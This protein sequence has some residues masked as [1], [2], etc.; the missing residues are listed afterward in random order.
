MRVGTYT[1]ISRDVTG[2]AL[3][4][5]RQQAEIDA[6]CVQRGWEIV[7]RYSDNDMSA[8]SLKKPRPQFQQMLRDVTAGKIDAIVAK[9][10]D[11]L[12]RRLTEL[13]SVLAVCEKAG[14]RIVTTADGVDTGSDGGRLVARILASVAQGEVE[15][16]S[17]RQKAAFVQRAERGIGWGPRAFG[18]TTKQDGDEIIRDEAAAVRDGYSMILAGGSLYSV[19][20]EWNRRGFRTN[21][22]K[23]WRGSTVRHVL[24]NSRYAGLRSYNGV[25]V[26]EAAWDA[27][28]ARDTWEGVKAI[29]SDTTRRRNSEATNTRV[30]LLAGIVSCGVCKRHLETGG[31]ADNRIYAC[32]KQGCSKLS[33]RQAPVDE[34]I[35][36]VIVARL[37]R[38]DAVEL[39]TPK[40]RADEMRDLLDQKRALKERQASM[41]ADWA[42]GSLTDEQIQVANRRIAERLKEIDARVYASASSQVFDGVVDADDVGRV[43]DALPL[44]RKRAIIVTLCSD[45]VIRPMGK[46]WRSSAENIA[47][48]IKIKW[49]A[50]D[51]S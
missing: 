20:M 37:S 4:V 16:K 40:G 27:I 5:D 51:G 34:Y 19:A 22:G 9:H 12:L 28:V 30:S 31:R 26:G 1:R 38:P 44:E 14:A 8:T 49:R 41:A 24:L 7:E 2:E 18:Y 43:W 17:A 39:M 45:I 10:L 32:K 33:R 13:E 36:D 15:R 50:V 11:R 47:R 46:G 21:T 23:L 42:D 6:Y 29:L 48:T 35:S 25:I 3:G